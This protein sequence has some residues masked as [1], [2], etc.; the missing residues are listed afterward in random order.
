VKPVLH[1][2]TTICRGGA[3]N[4]LLTLIREQVSTGRKVELIFLKDQPELLGELC[5]MGVEVHS[6]FSMLSPL[7]QL[8]SIRRF[9][10]GKEVL[11]HGHL[12][13]AELIAALSKGGN[14]LVV[15]RHNAEKFFPSAPKFL[16]SALSRYVI[17][18]SNAIIAISQS[19][20]DFL[21]ENKEL[22]KN[23]K[24]AVVYYG[25]QS[26]SQHADLKKLRES[27]NIP[28][29]AIVIGTVARLTTQ[30]DLPTL[31]H[32]FASLKSNEN[33]RLLMVG[34]GPLRDEL[35][36]MA[37]E[38]DIRD[39]VIWAGRTDKVFA[40]LNLMDIF[41]LTSTYEGFGLVLLEA[42][43]AHLPVIASNVSAVPEVLGPN[44]PGLVEPGNSQAFAEKITEFIL[45]DSVDKERIENTGQSRLEFFSAVKMR[46]KIDEVYAS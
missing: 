20:S 46:Q 44:Y 6:E 5:Q 4:Q 12:P 7:A 29:G 3:E 39:Q 36:S 41:V 15:T 26:N 21:H 13:R 27:L 22:P 16:S 9:L 30:K 43:E 34:D 19:V 1:V 31:L 18:R 42:L 33:L 32:A 23:V 2:I 28:L 45:L 24:P 8:V 11:I 37:I 38:L 25:Y 40:H 35:K 10:K 14:A 17:R